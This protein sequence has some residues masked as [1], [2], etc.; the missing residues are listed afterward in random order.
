M[1]KPARIHSL[2][3]FALAAAAGP[4]WAASPCPNVG[5]TQTRVA[6]ETAKGRFTY[7][8]EVAQ[9]ADQQAC[10]MMFRDKMGRDTGMSFPMVPARATGFWMENTALPLDIIFVSP[11]GRVLNVKR[12]EPYSREVLESAGAA[13]DVIELAAGE[14][15]RIGLKPGDRV[16]R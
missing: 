1:T 15:E 13:G 10:G 3:L 6:F 7:R 12:G 14:A 8:I 2:F 16:R 5:L 9:T 4:V 11:S